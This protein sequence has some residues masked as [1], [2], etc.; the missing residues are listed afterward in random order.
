[1]IYSLI[2]IPLLLATLNDLG[3]FFTRVLKKIWN[4][5]LAIKNWRK[6]KK[7]EG[8]TTDKTSVSSAELEE[9]DFP[10]PIAI[11]FIV[12]WILLCAKLF[13]LW[14]TEWSYFQVFRAF[15]KL[16]KIQVADNFFFQSVY[17]FYISLT[18][19]GLG[20][21]TPN[22]PKIMIVCFGLVIFGL[23]LV[24]MVINLIQ[25]WLARIKDK[26]TGK[27]WIFKQK[28]IS[29]NYSNYFMAYYR[30]TYKLSIFSICES[31]CNFRVLP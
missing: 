4:K 7:Q 9:F 16:K 15:L 25:S 11:A 21:I 28:P 10:L 18:T 6:A 12:V 3:K 1:M 17:F 23:T 27:K 20:D 26:T 24:T 29:S 13:C 14:E 31:H 30:S 8:N 5:I 22:H 19:I 2:G